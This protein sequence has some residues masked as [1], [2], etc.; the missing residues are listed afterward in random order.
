MFHSSHA[1]IRLFALGALLLL[2]LPFVA[3]CGSSS[4][5]STTT[6][7]SA[8]KL[9][10]G[11]V[12]DT[13]GLNDRGFNALAYQGLQTGQTKLGIDGQVKESKSND[14]YVPNLT[15]FA[16]RNYDLVIAVGFLMEAAVG[17]V[18]QQ[19]PNVKFAIIDGVPQDA[20]GTTLQLSNVASLLFKEQ[21]AGALVGVVSGMLEKDGKAPKNKNTIGA[22]GGVSI[23]PVNDYIAGYKWAALR[24]DPGVNVLVQYSNDFA[25]SAK[26]RDIANAMIG[27]GADILFQ[28]AGGCGLGVLQAAEQANVYSIGV[29]TDQKADGKTVIASALKRVEVATYDTIN[30]VSTSAFK[31]GVN[32]YGLNNDGVGYAPGDVSLPSD[33]QAAVSD[34]TAQIK[35]GTLTPPTTIP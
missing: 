2:S 6:S 12:T 14:D 3:A 23:P 4:T 26:C 32:T 5:T 33:I 21:D 17:Q 34:Y 31:S 28:V 11:L 19:F 22:V 35:A 1:R 25:D 8:K 15:F 24:V 30:A 7:T 16:T 13:G 10:V 29:D 27:K 9:K 20:K 18:A